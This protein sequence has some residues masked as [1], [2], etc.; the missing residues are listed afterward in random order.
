LG[1][2]PPG[3]R[4]NDGTK[5]SVISG[6]SEWTGRA[7]QAA[8]FWKAAGYAMRCPSVGTIPPNP[9]GRRV[10]G[11]KESVVNSEKKT[12]SKRARDYVQKVKKQEIEC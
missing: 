7:E 4:I 2:A 3:G 12:I 6:L 9:E 1:D 11:S 5:I 10:G 8:K